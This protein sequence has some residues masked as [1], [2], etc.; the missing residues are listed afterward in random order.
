M[1]WIDETHFVHN[2]IQVGE[3]MGPWNGKSYDY[4]DFKALLWA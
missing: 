4:I 1:A 2:E 3:W